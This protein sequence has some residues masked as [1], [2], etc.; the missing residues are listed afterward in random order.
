MPE[1]RSL[2]RLQFMRCVWIGGCGVTYGAPASGCSSVQRGVYV[3]SAPRG[4]VPMLRRRRSRRQ[5]AGG[6]DEPATN[7]NLQ[8]DP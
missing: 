1:L 8:A 7:E 6:K 3:Q 4:R 5:T 2:R